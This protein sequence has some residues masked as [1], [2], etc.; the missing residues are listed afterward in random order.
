MNDQSSTLFGVRF[1]AI[2]RAEALERL[3]ELARAARQRALPAQL[4]VTVNVQILV[5]ARHRCPRLLPI[6]NQAPLVVADGAPLVALSRV[7]PPRL[8][9]RVAGSDLIYDLVAAAARDGLRV[10]FFGGAEESTREAIEIF[11]RLHPALQVAGCAS[12]LI[13]LDPDDAQL[14]EE[15]DLCRQITDAQTDLLLV[16]L[17]CPKQELFVHRNAE[18]LKGLAAIGLGGSFNFVSGRVRRAPRWVQRIGMEWIY[19]I[20]QEPRRLFLR[21]FFDAFYLAAYAL[22]EPFRRRRLKRSA[23]P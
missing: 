14:A 10:F 5:I 12:P 21:Y 1:D 6:I 18:R 4:A 16:G 7:F 11:R 22:A 19:R 23:R 20:L 8:P 17:G 2:T 13:A 9:E 15:A 3:L